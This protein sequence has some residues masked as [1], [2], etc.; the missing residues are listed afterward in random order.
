M[1][2]RPLSSPP[3]VPPATRAKV[4]KFLKGLQQFR[5]KGLELFD[6]SSIRKYDETEVKAYLDKMTVGEQQAIS[7][8]IQMDILK[9]SPLKGGETRSRKQKSATRKASKASPKVKAAA[10]K[11]KKAGRRGEAKHK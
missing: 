8:R 2:N 6:E 1:R 11:K 4:A 3:P 9:S 7:R 10:V 5:A